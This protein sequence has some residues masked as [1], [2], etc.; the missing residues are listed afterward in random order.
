VAANP[1]AGLT[2]VSRTLGMGQ[3]TLQQHLREDGTS[4]ARERLE[5]RMARASE[6]LARGD[7]KVDAVARASGF[8]S[9]WSYTRPLPLPPK[10]GL[11]ISRSTP[12]RSKPAPR[13]VTERGE[14]HELHPGAL[15]QGA[16]LFES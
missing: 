2:E 15:A 11:S 10:T 4:F 6:L 9:R 3:R 5:L 14:S 13:N 7:E 16:E 8:R 12:R 1:D